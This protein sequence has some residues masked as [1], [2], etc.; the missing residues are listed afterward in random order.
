MSQSGLVKVSTGVLPPSVPLSFVTDSGTAVPVANTLNVNGTTALA[1]SL[2]VSTSAPGS[3]DIVDI[4]VQTSQAIAATD[5]TKIGLAAF[6]STDFTVDANGFVSVVGGA[7]VTSVAT[8]NA[9][10]QFVLAGSTETVDFGITNLA[11]G[12]SLSS[13]TSGTQNVF[14]GLNSGNSITSAIGNTGLGYS[15]LSNLI[16]GNYNLTLGFDSGSAY[17]GAE[18]SNILLLNSGVVGESNTIRIGTQGTGNGQQDTAYIAGIAGSTVVGNVVNISSTGELGELTALTNGQMYIGSTGVSP[19][20]AT[21]TGSGM[22]VS[23]GPGTLALSVTGG[24]YTWTNVTGASATVYSS[25]GYYA[26]NASQIA[27]TMNTTNLGDSAKIVGY[28]AGGWR[29]YPTGTQVF[30]VGNLTSTPT[31]G[32]IESTNQYDCI[33]ILAGLGDN[34]H[35]INWVGNITVV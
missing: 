17:V 6:N 19:V 34:L 21:I 5:A 3:T 7:P 11:L 9:T 29:L 33:E 1:G 23:I 28:G 8:A 13:L 26:N 22:S 16:S 2:P 4:T 35:I 31:T 18:S 32:Y 25:G 14:Y 20:A 12:S 30:H 27:F 10:A 24:G 15:S